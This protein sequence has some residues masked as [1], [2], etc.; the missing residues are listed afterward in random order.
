[1][2]IFSYGVKFPLELNKYNKF[3]VIEE[4]IPNIR[5]K[6]KNIILTNPGEK[7]M[8][9]EFGVGI[10]KYLFEDIK[11]IITVTLEGQ[12]KTY[13][14]ETFRNNFINLLN[15]QLNRYAPDIEIS[16][17][18]FTI[19][20]NILKISLGYNY[21]TYISDEFSLLITA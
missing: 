21:Q 14:L 15:K 9:P 6:L 3:E 4:I 19:E 20:E 12:N 8:D 7:L 13:T 10:K 16:S 5:Q 11:G 2:A 18:E 1:M 17:V